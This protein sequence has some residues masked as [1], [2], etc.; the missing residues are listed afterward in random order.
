[1]K[2]HLRPRLSIALAGTFAVAA[3]SPDSA[4]RPT[5]SVVVPDAGVMLAKGGTLPIVPTYTLTFQD[6]SRQTVTSLVVGSE[7]VLEAHVEDASGN[8]ATSGPV[9]FQYCSLKGGAPNQISRPDEAPSSAC[10][11]GTASWANL[12][13]ART[14]DQFGEVAMN[15]G[16]VT[17]P[18]TIGF[19]FKYSAR[20]SSFI[21]GTSAPQ[22]FTWVAAP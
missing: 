2:G 3:C 22:D 13:M 20:G 12:L 6:N 7:L 18:R 8:L 19:R 15:F 21:T 14:L 10:A 11:D 5:S 4:V 17:I 9:T 1:M 16:Y